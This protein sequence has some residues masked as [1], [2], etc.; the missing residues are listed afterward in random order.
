MAHV[1]GYVPKR[2][3]KLYFE[4]DVE[5]AI[6]NRAK[7][8]EESLKFLV[9]VKEN[10]VAERIYPVLSGGSEMW[11]SFPA[12]LDVFEKVPREAHIVGHKHGY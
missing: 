8:A 10:L 11:Y 7:A 1:V 12:L 6:V 9:M 5:L 3:I 2:M 4:D